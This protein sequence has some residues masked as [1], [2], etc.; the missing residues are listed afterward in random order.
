M[1][2]MAGKAPLL[3]AM[4][5]FSVGVAGL[6]LTSAERAKWGPFEPRAAISSG[7]AV[8]YVP[9]GTA[10]VPPSLN[11]LFTS[12]V[13]AAPA[14][15][16]PTALLAQAP[17][18]A[19]ADEPAA[20]ALTPL[21]VFGISADG[22]DVSAAAATPAPKPLRG[23]GVAADDAPA[24]EATETPSPAATESPSANEPSGEVQAG[25]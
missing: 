24:P 25:D 20:P 10:F 19:V 15:E 9:V 1:P 18:E 5:L 12:S 21:R 3:L 14:P 4:V 17:A 22:G 6:A 13:E 23:I 16:E 2:S 11:D 8:V 7:Q